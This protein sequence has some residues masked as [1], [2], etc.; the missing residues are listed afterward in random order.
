[1]LET[2]DLRQHTITNIHLAWRILLML[3]AR[4][5]KE[6]NY[7][8]FLLRDDEDLSIY[9][10]IKSVRTV[11]TQPTKLPLFELMFCCMVRGNEEVMAQWG[12]QFEKH[13][14]AATAAFRLSTLQI[15]FG[16]EVLVANAARLLPFLCALQGGRVL[17][18]VPEA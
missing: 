18:R 7:S 3:M 15:M 4:A 5:H 1:M 13:I 14:P 9:L 12:S 2:R 17:S 6:K 16:K 11:R 10:I 8:A